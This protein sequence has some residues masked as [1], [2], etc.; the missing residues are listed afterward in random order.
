MEEILEKKLDIGNIIWISNEILSWNECGRSELTI[1]K[2]LRE[3][4][5]NIWKHANELIEFSR[6]QFD[7]EDGIIDLKRALNHRLK[8]IEE[9][10][11][12]KKNIQEYKKLPY[13]EILERL[14]I[15]RPILF[16]DLFQ[17]RNAIEHN[18]SRPPEKER[19]I[20]FSDIVWLFLKVT[21]TIVSKQYND[22]EYQKN[23][24]DLDF[25]NIKIDYRESLNIYIHAR[26]KKDI[27][28]INPKEDWIALK[29]ND[30]KFLKNNKDDIV[31]NGIIEEFE[32][33][34]KLFRI[35]FNT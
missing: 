10:Y 7:L 32:R 19:C 14:E 12:L 27:I 13:L 6:N 31:I 33:K 29:L 3:R 17:V 9:I 18:D 8:I 16:R 34:E 21:D 30:Y 15:I 5:Y 1:N 24:N 11:G 4:S 2:E 23:E 25:Y 35:I 26:V 28:S 22:L 20:E